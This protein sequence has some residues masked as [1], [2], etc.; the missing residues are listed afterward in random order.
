MPRRAL[1]ERPLTEAERQRRS[2]ERRKTAVTEMEVA[3]RR[4][5]RASTLNEARKIAAAALQAS[6]KS[7][8]H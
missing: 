8:K 3:L 4:I 1:G 6:R 5:L 7:P 2:R